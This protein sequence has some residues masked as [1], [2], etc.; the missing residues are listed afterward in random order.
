MSTVDR[1]DD[2]VV[3]RTLK[4]ILNTNNRTESLNVPPFFSLSLQLC[5]RQ[6]SLS[7][8][9]CWTHTSTWSGM[10]QPA[11]PTSASPSISTAAACLAPCSQR[12][13]ASGTAATASGR[14]STSTAPAHP[15]CPPSKA[16]TCTYITWSSSL[17]IPVEKMR[18]L[19]FYKKHQAKRKSKIFEL[20]DKMKL[21]VIVFSR[22]GFDL[23]NDA[24]WSVFSVERT[25]LDYKTL[26]SQQH[27]AEQT[28]PTK[29]PS[30]PSANPCPW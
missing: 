2:Q 11:S 26:S 22:R 27:S 29:C 6:S 18:Y 9:S 28:L 14:T 20:K 3:I 21:N 7:T 16:I 8:P 24:T 30:A 10:R 19:S 25:I 17:I 15:Q 23:F 12:R 4:I 1:K 5:P 13:P